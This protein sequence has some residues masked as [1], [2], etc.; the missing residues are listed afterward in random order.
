MASWGSEQGPMTSHGVLLSGMP[1]ESGVQIVSSKTSL[2][3]RVAVPRVCVS[4]GQESLQYQLRLVLSIESSM[5]L[6]SGHSP[7]SL[8]SM[9][10][11]IIILPA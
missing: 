3:G 7:I 5:A 1:T 2:K 4:K 10:G 6:A 11:S 8:A 9:M